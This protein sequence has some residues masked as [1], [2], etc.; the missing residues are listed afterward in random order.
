[1]FDMRTTQQ[2]FTNCKDCVTKPQVKN[3]KITGSQEVPF[4]FPS[5]HNTPAPQG[6]CYSDLK[7]S[8]LPGFVCYTAETT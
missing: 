8:C 2:F 7:Q 4:T 5:R 6:N 1:M 3:P